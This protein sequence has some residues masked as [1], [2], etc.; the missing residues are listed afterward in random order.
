MAN[1][2]TGCLTFSS[3]K[4]LDL[5]KCSKNEIRNY[6]LNSY[7]LNESIFTVLKDE[8]TFYFYPDK[9]RL[10]L[11]FYYGHTAAVYINKLIL[12]GLIKNRVNFEF[13]TLF[14]TGV[15]EMS[16][17]D[18]VSYRFGGKFQ[19][20]SVKDVVEYRRQVKEMI[21][22]VIDTTTLTLPVTMDSPWW[23]LF[24]GMEHE[25]IHL[26]TTS[27]LIRQ[28]PVNMVEKPL[29]WK[30]AALNSDSA[31]TEN[32]FLVVE[33][34]K[35]A[36]GKPR[37]FPSYGW[38]NEYGE[39]TL[40]VPKFEATKYLITN[41]DFLKFVLDEG[42]QRREFWSAEGWKWK[43]FR[44]AKHPTFWVCNQNCKNGSGGYLTKLSHCQRID[45]GEVKS[46]NISSEYHFRLMFDVVDLPLN[47]PVEVNYHEAKAFCSWM[48]PDYRLL[49]EAEMV[50]IRGNQI[51]PTE[52]VKCDLIHSD[53][54]AANINLKFGSS[55]PV[56]FFKP[57]SRGFHDTQGNVWQWVEDHFN[58]LNGFNSHWL[59]D[60]FSTPC[61]DGRHNMILGGSWIST[62]NEASRFARFSF[63]RHFFQHLGFRVAKSA[64]EGITIPA[65]LVNTPIYVTDNSQPEEE[66]EEAPISSDL[67]AHPVPSSNS[68]YV[69]DEKLNLSG[70]IAL[71]F[72]IRE[73]LAATSV[74]MSLSILH[75]MALCSNSALVIGCGTGRTAFEL[76]KDFTEVLAIDYSTKLLDAAERMKTHR[77]VTT[78]SADGVEKDYF[79]DNDS[80]PENVIFKQLTWLSN[81]IGRH[82]LIMVMFLERVHNPNAWLVRLW[83]TVSGKGL[84]VIV[85]KNDIWTHE[86]L[87]PILNPRMIHL[88]EKVCNYQ[89]PE[90]VETANLSVWSVEHSDE[91]KSHAN[92]EIL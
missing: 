7:S 31:V 76:S 70:I 62:G 89:T 5:S 72:G 91:P 23:S 66:L 9:L 11:I 29:E 55:T 73:S 60:D 59:Y 44:E 68:Q 83:E 51:S 8:R 79:V 77:H 12:T 21:L 6:F 74:Q 67:V 71:E 41:G 19:W 75:Q 61:F 20:P 54:Q 2:L 33:G 56:N 87:L 46:K 4:Q 82:D 84:V 78:T 45:H 52:G 48:G 34:G 25:R 88:S 40:Q 1:I 86:K 58:G 28:L 90:G 18:T 22:N 32:P 57:S 92:G 42:Y 15:D 85:S 30:Y 43:T 64:N 37:N 26:E 80:R 81:E 65:R 49:T 35:V 10:P 14:E 27:V 13:E 39:T 50:L 16:W 38:D 36:L 47:W 17:D 24:M 63:R 69:F 3:V 53:D